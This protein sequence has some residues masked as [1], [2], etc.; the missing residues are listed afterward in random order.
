MDKQGGSINQS[1]VVSSERI[2]GL[3]VHLPKMS[4]DDPDGKGVVGTSAD[5]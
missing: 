5:R 2:D 3:V 4:E 1:V